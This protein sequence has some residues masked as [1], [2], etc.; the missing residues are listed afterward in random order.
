MAP[1]RL[2]LRR[3]LRYGFDTLPV[4]WP[5]SGTFFLPQRVKAARGPIFNWCAKRLHLVA[6]RALVLALTGGVNLLLPEPGIQA[7]FSLRPSLVNLATL[8]VTP[9]PPL[10][11]PAVASFRRA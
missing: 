10:S 8:A 6:H 4:F 7:P 1:L 5:G 9:A 2:W 11:S 3:R